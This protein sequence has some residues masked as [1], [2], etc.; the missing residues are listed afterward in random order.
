VT[1]AACGPGDPCGPSLVAVL[2]VLMLP[3]C[4]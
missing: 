3:L 4:V 1:A 2:Q